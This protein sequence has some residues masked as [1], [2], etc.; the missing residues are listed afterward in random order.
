MPRAACLSQQLLQTRVA[1]KPSL[2]VQSLLA[3]FLEAVATLARAQGAQQCLQDREVPQG[4]P[5]LLLRVLVLLI[6]GIKVVDECGD[7]RRTSP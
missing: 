5:T 4:K 3:L 6:H 1:L 7:T 2:I